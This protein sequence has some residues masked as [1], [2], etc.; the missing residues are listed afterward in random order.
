[1]SKRVKVS[2]VNETDFMSVGPTYDVLLPDNQIVTLR[3]RNGDDEDVLSKVEDF[4]KGTGIPK[5]LAGLIQGNKLTW[6]EVQKWKVRNKYYLMY[7]ERMA[8]FGSVVE[9][10]HEF[11]DGTKVMFEEDI[12]RFDRNFTEKLDP[13]ADIVEGQIVP[14]PI[15]YDK[16]EGKTSSGKKYRCDYLTGEGEIRTLDK[17][18]NTLSINERLRVRNF[19]LQ[20]ADGTWK[21]VEKFSMLTA[22]EMSEIRTLVDDNDPMFDLR[23]TVRN[24]KDG[25]PEEVSMFQ[26]ATFFFPRA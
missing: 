26:L 17:T 5:F 20:M 24:P 15:G 10:E 8:N 11:V 19:E 9:W 1:M 13:E 12:A 6:Q 7:K 3:E 2:N 18:V 22:R 25:T 16:I 21:L 14:Y 4:Q 23:V